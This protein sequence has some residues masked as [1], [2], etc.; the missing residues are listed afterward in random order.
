[1]GLRIFQMSTAF[2]APSS[3][4]AMRAAAKPYESLVSCATAANGARSTVIA[5]G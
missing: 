1:M 3:I 5:G 2:A 4:H